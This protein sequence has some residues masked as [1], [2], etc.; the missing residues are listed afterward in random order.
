M[1]TH[2]LLQEYGFLLKKHPILKTDCNLQ[3]AFSFNNNNF[4][5]Q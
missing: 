5:F 3:A 2:C 4:L 1:S